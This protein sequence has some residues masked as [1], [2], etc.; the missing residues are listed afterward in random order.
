MAR[1]NIGQRG[2]EIIKHFEGERNSLCGWNAVQKLYYPYKDA[3]GIWTIGLGTIVYPNG[4]RV[5]ETDAPI[6]ETEAVYLLNFELDEKEDAVVKMCQKMNWKPEDHQFD[7]L[8]SMAYNCGIGILDQTSSLRK[9]LHTGRVDPE[10]KNAFMMYVKGTKKILG[11]KTKVT[12]PG[13]V[14]RRKVE[15]HLFS[16]GNVNFNV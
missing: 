7:A 2:L 8:V 12:L 14:K 6:T 15:Y 5:K 3:V 4:L 9:A 13:L 16:T 1:R 11:V 10:I